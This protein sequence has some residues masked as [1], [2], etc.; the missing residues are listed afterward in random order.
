MHK[1]LKS[2]SICDKLRAQVYVI[3]NLKTNLLIKFDILESQKIN[4]NYKKKLLVINNCKDITI[5]I[6]VTLI[7]N[8]INRI[9]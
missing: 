7:K 2:V 6:I 9:V 5:F 4:L 1:K 3:N 8:K